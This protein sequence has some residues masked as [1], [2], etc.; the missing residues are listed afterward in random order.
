MIIDARS[1]R[2]SLTCTMIGGSTGIAQSTKQIHG[3]SALSY[4][5]EITISK[6]SMGSRMGNDSVR[7]HLYKGVSPI[8][9]VSHH[10]LTCNFLRDL[11]PKDPYTLI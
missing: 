10:S 8:T 1:R 7:M 6:K 5:L 2:K 3:R 11:P 4:K 9:R